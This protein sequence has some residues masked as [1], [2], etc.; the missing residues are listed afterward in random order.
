M[1]Q[2]RHAITRYCAERTVKRRNAAVDAHRYLCAHR[3]SSSARATFAPIWRSSPPSA[4]QGG[5]ELWG[6]QATPGSRPTAYRS[7]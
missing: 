2:Q 3:A 7:A 6:R 1:T 5:D 4:G